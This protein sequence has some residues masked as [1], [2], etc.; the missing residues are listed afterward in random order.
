MVEDG[1]IT[2][3]HRG[4]RT[5]GPRTRGLTRVV[6]AALIAYWSA[7]AGAPMTGEQEYQFDAVMRGAGS[8]P[9]RG[10]TYSFM[11]WCEPE[12]ADNQLQ[13]EWGGRQTFTMTRVVDALC[14]HGAGAGHAD[15]TNFGT[16]RGE[17][18]GSYDGLDGA[19]VAWTFTDG[20][21]GRGD[22][23]DLTIRDPDGAVVLQVS[24]LVPEGTHRASGTAIL[25]RLPRVDRDNVVHS[26]VIDNA[27]RPQR[28][29]ITPLPGSAFVEEPG[30]GPVK[31]DAVPEP[32]LP[33]IHSDL[34]ATIDRGGPDDRVVVVVNLVDN[35]TVP[36]FPDLPRGVT[37]DSREGSVLAATSAIV[38]RLDE[39]RRR[40]VEAFLRRLARPGTPAVDVRMLGRFWLVKAFLADVRLGDV[41]TLAAH[42]EVVHIQPNELAVPVTPPNHDG[43]PPHLDVAAGRALMGTDPYLNLNGMAGGYIGLID[44]G[45]K[46]HVLIQ[47]PGTREG[48]CVHGNANCGPSGDPLFSNFDCH[49]HGTSSAAVLDGN[50]SLGDGTRGVTDIIVDRWKVWI[51]GPPMCSGFD[52][53]TSDAVV[54]AFQAGL[55]VLDRTFAVDI[56]PKEPQNGVMATAA[57][58][59]FDA[60]AVVVAA[61]GNCAVDD[62]CKTL[63]GPPVPGTVRSPAV[64]QKVFGVGAFNVVNGTTGDYQG[65]G[66]APDGR[67]KPDIQAPTDVKTASAENPTAL[68]L[69]FGGTSAATPFATGAAAL[70]RNWLKK[71]NTF[72]PGS[73]YARLILSGDQVFSALPGRS[74]PGYSNVHG[75]GHMRL[76]DLC[77][78]TTNWGKVTVQSFFRGTPVV[79]IPILV[80]SGDSL[81]AAIWWPEEAF[82]KHN[83]IDLVVIDPLGTQRASALS[84]PS[85]FE[86]AV[87]VGPLLA[88]TWK[89]QISGYSLPTNPQTVYWTA[90]VRGDCLGPPPLP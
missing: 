33:K 45:S 64:A 40:S 16:H 28:F 4:P 90:D 66:P 12:A 25:P 38:R 44:S 71:F 34:E 79:E 18:D 26:L 30:V 1:G 67:V 29:T 56:Q 6:V 21:R 70:M 14:I 47:R 35:L 37:R 87:V 82:A 63:V 53:I 50:G 20:R 58:K 59:T 57:N 7:G 32:V 73:T 36:R 86:R 62:T 31:R 54:R 24:G 61:N 48:D 46:P 19:H 17:G 39:Q 76:P 88:G 9:G 72:D 78:V 43:G 27:G 42:P 23:V 52:S 5:R 51:A 89:L 83:D 68:K 84:A 49:D 85:V 2:S 81:E 10:V 60:G 74:F 65:R 75:A 41:R 77:S 69:R 13:V 22:R 11:L 8:L 3:S 80:T 55:L 15:T